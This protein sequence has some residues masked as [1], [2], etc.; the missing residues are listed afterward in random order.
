MHQL[1]TMQFLRNNMDKYTSYTVEL[2]IDVKHKHVH[3]HTIS[4]DIDP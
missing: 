2:D 4:Y 3:T 1:N